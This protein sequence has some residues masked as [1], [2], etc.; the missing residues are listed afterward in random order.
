M[1]RLQCKGRHYKDVNC[2][3]EQRWEEG[4][5]NI[6][7]EGVNGHRYLGRALKGEGFIDIQGVPGDDLGMFADGVTVRVRGNAQD[8]VG[9]TMNAGKIIVEGDVRDITGH[10]M[11]GGKIWVGGNAGYRLGIHMKSFQDDYPVIIVGGNTGDFLGEYMAG[12][13]IIV[14]NLKEDGDTPSVGNYTATGMHGGKIF[15]RGKISQEQVG[16]GIGLAPPGE[17][18]FL[19]VSRYLDEYRKDL[20][21]HLP[22][23]DPNSF[24]KLFPLTTRPYG[25]LYAY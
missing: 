20:E 6:F 24:T 17:K 16:R 3:V 25:R 7:L 11:R 2:E 23:L 9:N 18:D 4:E 21:I 1:M 12:G 5:R 14:L 13:L 15:I 8:G 19:E 22:S 10:S